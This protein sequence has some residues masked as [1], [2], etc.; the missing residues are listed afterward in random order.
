MNKLDVINRRAYADEQVVSWYGRLDHIYQAEAVILKK[1][2][3]FIK[4]KTLLDIGIGAGRTTRYLLEISQDYTGIDYTAA[5]AAIAKTRYPLGNIFCADARQLPAPDQAF[6]FVLFS[7]SGIDYIDHGDRLKALREIHRVLRPG[8]FYMFS[9]HNR[10]YKNFKKMPWQEDTPL[11][12]GHLKSCLYS[13][14][15]WPRHLRM[16]KHEVDT[17]QYAIVNDS[18]H[19]FSLLAYYISADEQVKQLESEGFRDIEIYN[20][21]GETVKSDSQFP[22]IYYLASKP[23]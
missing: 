18:A 2:D 21:E 23:L 20:M 9:T 19:G 6:D 10:E 7:L 22:W 12:L 17:D 14:A 15:Y 4:D 5:L 8:G 16:K 1:L 11:T 3:P 13:L